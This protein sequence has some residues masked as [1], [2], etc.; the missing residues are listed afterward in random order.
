MNTTGNQIIEALE[1]VLADTKGAET[2]IRR[3][4]VVVPHDGSGTA[5][6][7]TGGTPSIDEGE[8]AK[9]RRA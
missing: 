5:S 8:H 6:D 7:A 2:G 1:E 4:M 3:H 9:R